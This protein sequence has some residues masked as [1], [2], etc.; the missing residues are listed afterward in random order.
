MP[1]TRVLSSISDHHYIMYHS[2][3]LVLLVWGRVNIQFHVEDL[4]I[5]THLIERWTPDAPN[6]FT[7]DGS[8]GICLDSRG[9]IQLWMVDAG[10]RLQPDGFLLLSRLLCTAV[11]H[12]SQYGEVEGIESTRYQTHQVFEKMLRAPEAWN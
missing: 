6:W 12:L 3:H 8:Y 11:R 5:L 2:E 1:N 4:T 7:P 9:F 10:L